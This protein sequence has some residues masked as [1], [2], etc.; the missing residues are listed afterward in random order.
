MLAGY[1]LGKPAALREL[2]TQE[3]KLEIDQLTR[4][5]AIDAARFLAAVVGTAHAEQMGKHARNKWQMVLEQNR[6][7]SSMRRH[8]SGSALLNWS[9]GMNPPIGNIAGNMH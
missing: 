6:S 8:G 9:R 1:C 3:L 7:K 2:L 4:K 5:E